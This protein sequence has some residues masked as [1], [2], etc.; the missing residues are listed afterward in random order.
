MLGKTYT[1]TLHG[2]D[3]ALTTVEADLSKGLPRFHIVGLTDTIIKESIERIRG[4]FLNR[5]FDFPMCRITVNLSPADK[6][7]SGS[8]YDLP[9]AIAILAARAKG[10]NFTWDKF[11]FFGELTLEGKVKGVPGILPLVICAEE[12][13]I[14]NIVVPY[15]NREEAAMTGKSNI[16]PVKSLVEAIEFING[17]NDIPKYINGNLKTQETFEK[18]FAQVYGQE[19]AKRAVVIGAAGGHN[20]IMMG[21]PGCGKTMMA[22]RI[23]SIL[24]PLDYSEKIEVTKIYSVAG[25]SSE[26]IIRR[27]KRP[28]RKPYSNITKVGLFG[29]GGIPK[30]GEISLAHKGVLFLDEFTNFDNGCIDGLRKPLDE[31]MVHIV[32]NRE[33]VSFPAQCML[34]IASNP[35]KCGYRGD[36]TH[37]CT[38]SQRTIDAFYEKFNTP[39]MDRIDLYVSMDKVQ[40]EDIENRRQSVNSATMR[41]N[42]LKAREMQ[43]VRFKDEKINSNGQM[44][45]KLIEK[46]CILQKEEQELLKNAFEVM[47]MSLRAYHK[48]IKVSRTIADVE[49]S[50]DIKKEHIAEALQYREKYEK[51]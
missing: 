35:C 19:S 26:D 22:E 1:A 21:S 41:E 4:S 38:C 30:P 2:V 43:K 9:I 15:A 5:G 17:E 28:F 13:G 42:V 31:G 29:G 36:A 11:A 49:G 51:N 23:P 32:R 6:R 39:L 16:F 37:M 18:D 47:K 34:V 45:E 12:A 44:D 14:E 8:H 48:V 25:M 27:G 10:I 40:Y 3:G 20:I 50:K 33:K 24:P 7:K 46:Y